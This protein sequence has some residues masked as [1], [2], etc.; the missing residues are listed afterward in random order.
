VQDAL[1]DEVVEVTAK[2]VAR[3]AKG[4]HNACALARACERELK[5]DAAII[6]VSRA[7]LVYGERAIRYRLTERAQR[8]IVSFDRGAAFMPGKYV[9]VAPSNGN[10]MGSTRDRTKDKKKTRRRRAYRL[11][12]GIRAGMQRAT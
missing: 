10:R 3:S 9:L 6:A 12:Q 2:D 4:N 7:F 11:T 5:A 1:Q 8:E